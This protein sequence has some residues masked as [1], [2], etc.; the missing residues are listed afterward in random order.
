LTI[1][2]LFSAYHNHPNVEACIEWA[3][4]GE[5]NIHLKGLSGSSGILFAARTI[6][7][8]GGI[9]W[10][11][12]PD[13]EQAAYIY[14]DLTHC[15]NEESVLFFPSGYKRTMTEKTNDEAG[16][17]LRTEVLNRIKNIDKQHGPLVFVSYAEAMMEKVITS[18]TLYKNTLELNVGELISIHFIREVLDEYHFEEVE[19]VYEPGQYSVRGSIVDI[20]SYSHHLPYRVD[21]FDD[22]VESI[23]TF[24]VD[25]QLSR[26]QLT[27]I[28]IVPNIQKLV[29]KDQGNGVLKLVP[30][31][32]ILWSVNL[33][34]C[35]ERINE[36]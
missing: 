1:K 17:I 20:F 3:K 8:L 16:L 35:I 22:E 10:F 34:L 27:S 6:S 30:T 33:G 23:R 31:H 21:F 19:F 15:L 28:T 11:L 2:E 18:A 7:K 14:S 29:E 12:L 13:R 32:S 4:R 9:H 5:G 25:D 24:G 36:V 26:D